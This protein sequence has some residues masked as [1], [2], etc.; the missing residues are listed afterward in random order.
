MECCKNTK[1]RHYVPM[2]K[3]EATQRFIAFAIG[4]L[5]SLS[6]ALGL[7]LIPGLPMPWRI[8]LTV[9]PGVLAVPAFSLWKIRK[10]KSG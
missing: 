5:A 1:V 9:A 6:L 8:G 3:S 4:C 10:K 2:M 7:L